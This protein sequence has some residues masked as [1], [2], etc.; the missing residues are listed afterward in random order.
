MQDEPDKLE[1]MLKRDPRYRLGAYEFLMFAALPYTVDM[2]DK[3]NAAETDRHIT[4][5]QLLDGVRR[6]ALQEFGYL[7]RTVFEAW[8]VRATLDWGNIVYN[9]IEAELM[10]KTDEDSLGDFA[11]LYDFHE[12]LETSYF[13]KK[14][15]A[16][17]RDE[18]GRVVFPWPTPPDRQRAPSDP[19]EPLP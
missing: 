4:G 11:D 1:A 6:L 18:N 10:N 9:L 12:A 3:R 17:E 19:P 15:Y 14:L 16:C 8:G 5:Q 7:A 2:L 13:E